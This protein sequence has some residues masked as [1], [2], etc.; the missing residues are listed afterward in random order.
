MKKGR[1]SSKL[2]RSVVGVLGAPARSLATGG[3]VLDKAGEEELLSP[4]PNMEEHLAQSLMVQRVAMT[5]TAQS[6][7]R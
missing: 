7:V 4:N 1:A 5:F 6:T 3:V 2:P